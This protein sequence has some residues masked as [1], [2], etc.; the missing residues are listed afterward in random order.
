MGQAIPLIGHRAKLTVSLRP[1][2]VREVNPHH[3]SDA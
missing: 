1:A 3:N 2:L